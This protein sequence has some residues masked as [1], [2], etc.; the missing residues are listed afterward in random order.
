MKTFVYPS[1]TH[2]L[3][4]GTFKKTDWETVDKIW[5]PEFKITLGVPQEASSEY[6]YGAR[7]GGSCGLQLV[8]EE[9]DF[10]QVDSA[11]KLLTSTDPR[12]A[13]DASEHLKE[14]IMKRYHRTIDADMVSEYMSGAIEG[15]MRAPAVEVTNG[16][17]PRE[18]GLQE[19][20]R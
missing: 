7:K 5:R 10:T 1:V 16:V 13:S 19:V 2:F 17:D 6:L 20:Q 12:I 9:S 14:T 18:S 11:F 4:V 3:R 8:A 15:A